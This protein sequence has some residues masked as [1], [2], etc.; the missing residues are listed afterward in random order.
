ML[1]TPPSKRKCAGKSV[2]IP[3]I[4][5]VDSDGDGD[6]PIHS[7]KRKGK[8]RACELDGNIIDLCD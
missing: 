6:L 5:S 1:P 8:G 2:G 4:N 7:K 3:E